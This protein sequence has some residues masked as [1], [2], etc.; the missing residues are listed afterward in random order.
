MIGLGAGAEPGFLDL[1]EIAD[2]HLGFQHRTG[3][4]PG[5]RADDR[6]RG[7]RCAFEMRKRADPDIVGHRNAGAEDD[8][9]LDDDIASKPR[10]G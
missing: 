5:E 4:Q 10:I 8:V 3:T 7:D 6:A 2:M 9:R 1:D